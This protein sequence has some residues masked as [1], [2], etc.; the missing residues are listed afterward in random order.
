VPRLIDYTVG[1]GTVFTDDYAR[2]L[3]IRWVDADLKRAAREAVERF[4]EQLK[5]SE[6]DSAN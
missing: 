2:R 6:G 4:A 3:V 1:E 5:E